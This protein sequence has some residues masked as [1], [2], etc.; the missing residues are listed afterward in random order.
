MAVISFAVSLGYIF[1]RFG[2]MASVVY[3]PLCFFATL[4]F[5]QIIGSIQNCHSRSV[6]MTF[7]TV[8]IWA[9]LF[10]VGYFVTVNLFTIKSVIYYIALAIGFVVSITSGHIQ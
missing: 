3:V 9:I 4:G 6:S 2:L 1:A 5:C 7:T 8:I 10:A